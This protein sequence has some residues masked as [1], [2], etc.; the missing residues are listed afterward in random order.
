MS[1]KRMSPKSK[2]WT[3][4]SV[5]VLLLAA[6]AVRGGHFGSRATLHAQAAP[7]YPVFEVDKN[8]PPP[9]PYNWIVGHVPSI[10]V[11]PALSFLLPPAGHQG[12]A[13]EAT[14]TRAARP[15][16]EFDAN[17]KFVNAW[18][19]PGIPGF[20]WPDSEHGITVD[21]KENVWIGGSAPVAPS[22][23]TSMTTCS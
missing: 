11:D 5:T 7:R 1:V 19:G 9:L 14:V 22:L 6:G 2:R 15:V 20:D 4:A 3:C 13:T 18:G 16:M 17:G 8:W 23:R 12:P 10:A 21:Y